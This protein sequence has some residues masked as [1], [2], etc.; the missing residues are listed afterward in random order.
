M[1]SG[2]IRVGWP[3]P[4][5]NGVTPNARHSASYSSLESPRMSALYPNSSI[6]MMNSLTHE[7][8]PVPGLPMMNTLGLVTGISSSSTHPLGSQ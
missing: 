7:D 6:R 8:F 4:M 5:A 3:G 1:S 2:L